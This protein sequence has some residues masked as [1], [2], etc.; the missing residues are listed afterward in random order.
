MATDNPDAS[1]IV[2]ELSHEA[3]LKLEIIESLQLLQ[4]WEKCKRLK[5]IVTVFNRDLAL[6]ESHAHS[7]L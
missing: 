4:K 6:N 5:E 1:A 7:T 2:T 3:K